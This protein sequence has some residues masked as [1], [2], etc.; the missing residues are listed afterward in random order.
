MPSNIERK[1]RRKR[2]TRLTFDPVNQSSSPSLSSPA[3][4]RYALNGTKRTPAS[5]RQDIA[6]PFESDD[7]LSSSKKADFSPAAQKNGKLPF[8][9][10]PTP[11]KSSQIQVQSDG[12]LDSLSTEHDPTTSTTS[13]KTRSVARFMPAVRNKRKQRSLGFDGAHDSSDDSK[14]ESDFTPSKKK[15]ASRKTQTVVDLVSNSDDDTPSATPTKKS[16]RKIPSSP[17]SRTTRSSDA[18]DKSR[19][20]KSVT[21]SDTDDDIP[22][23]TSKVVRKS[24]A[25]RGTPILPRLRTS[26]KR[27]VNDDVDDSDDDPIV[28]SPKRSQ[29]PTYQVR[30]DDD[31]EE[32]DIRSSPLKRRARQPFVHED[33][34]EDEEPIISPQKRSRR[35]VESEDSEDIEVSPT[36]RRRHST[37]HVTDSDSDSDE[38]PSPSRIPRGRGRASESDTPQRT[39]RQQKQKKKHRT[40][41]EKNMELL[42]KRR[43]GDNTP[44]TDSESDSDDS[45]EDEFEQLDEFDDE[46]E[47]DVPARNVTKSEQAKG[48]EDVDSDNFVT[49]DEE[50]D[51]NIGIPSI[52][53]EF[54]H[55]AHKQLKEHFKDAVEW[56]V[57]NKINP[58]FARDDPIYKQAF[59]KLNDECYGLAKS[60][61]S[62]TQWTK[63]FTRAVYARPV[64]EEQPLQAGEGFDM[65]SGLPK[66]WA[67]NH[68]K[69]KPSCVLI[70]SGKA[71][72]KDTLEELD[73][74]GS[75]DDTEES[76]HSENSDEKSDSGNTDEA[77]SVNSQG[78]DIPP[79]TTRYAVGS[80]CKRNAQQ[81]HTLI[82]WKYNLNQWVIGA[83]EEA[84]ELTPAKL[85]EREAMNLKKRTKY[86][87]AVVDNWEASRQIK[88]LWR[89]YKNQTETAR[90]LKAK[91]K[92]GWQ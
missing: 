75:S 90:E 73:Q 63:E 13:Q 86:A 33:E 26:G 56:M 74:S 28:S 22:A 37:Q 79:A 83:L 47:E 48:V 66:C 52:P 36:K 68:K 88:D 46:E 65:A 2:Q 21:L 53:L 61:F 25:G 16:T 10:L 55:H 29:K 85:A 71:Y 35:N 50:Q 80:V 44:L 40:E 42:R 41:R 82:H 5:S 60:K 18:K 84:G 14:S 58:A 51:G 77:T 1:A 62:S 31:E 15:P 64:L 69:Y 87:N 19:R 11:A 59:K 57:H 6:D 39:T 38:L 81:S 45:E 43:N 76:E 24:L 67:C 54:T 17:P 49:D 20:Q 91:S 27:V 34:D 7:V 89:D 4:V 70:F 3:Q 12:L 8:K 30:Q 92:G 9:A 78:Q 72:D 32:E 23:P